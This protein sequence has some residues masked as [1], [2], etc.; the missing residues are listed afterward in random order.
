MDSMYS[1]TILTRYGREAVTDYKQI[2]D[3]LERLQA[4]K[5]S[6]VRL[7]VQPP[8]N[9]IR[10]VETI[11]DTVK[12]EF[13]HCVLEDR[14]EGQGFLE[15]TGLK[16]EKRWYW[17]LFRWKS[18]GLFYRSEWIVKP[19]GRQRHITAVGY[20]ERLAMAP[21][22][23]RSAVY[24][25]KGMYGGNQNAPKNISPYSDEGIAIRHIIHK[26]FPEYE[27]TQIKAF[28]EKL[29][30]EGCGY[31]VIV[32]MLLEHFEERKA[33]FEEIFG[34]PLYT[35]SGDLNYNQ[36]L[37][38]FYAATDN[39]YFD[40]QKDCVNYE[41][42]RN[43]KEKK[44]DYEY[45]FDN[46]G[47]GT[48]FEQ[49]AYRTMLYLKEKGIKVRAVNH[50]SVDLGT[51]R[52]RCEKGYVI[53]SLNGGNVQNEDGSC[54]DYCRGHAMM[55]TGVTENG[56]YIVSTWGLKKYVDP[57][58]VIVKEEKKTKIYYQYIEIE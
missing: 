27:E 30:S 2:K 21:Y 3:W 33:E 54:Y 41:E 49:R 47:W 36:L 48:N 34:L 57:N 40:G 18:L 10:Y 52:S 8:I 42:D 7:E 13:Y 44:T 45:S 38:D 6:F 5:S 1:Y 15:R 56:R 4:E 11:Y 16:V 26:Y 53:I 29:S 14:P 28:L 50:A 35:G 37:V 43:E 9:G 23:R 58:E 19:T 22:E 51:F 32:N 25:E 17:K 24:D 39:H 46:T 55:I 20:E 12:Q 31:V